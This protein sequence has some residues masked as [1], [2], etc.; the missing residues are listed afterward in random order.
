MFC[1][2]FSFIER[3]FRESIWS[4]TVMFW[5]VWQWAGSCRAHTAA[6]RPWAVLRNQNRL[7]SWGLPV[8]S[9]N[10]I[11][12]QSLHR[13]SGFTQWSHFTVKIQKFWHPSLI[14][15]IEFI[16]RCVY[17][18]ILLGSWLQNRWGGDLLE[19]KLRQDS[20]AVIC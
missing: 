20:G 9:S 1:K 4:H 18:Y 13:C 3:C 11:H 6:S 10:P 7:H 17:I 16:Y 5:S 15:L 14:W 2:D 19:R 8:C 12:G